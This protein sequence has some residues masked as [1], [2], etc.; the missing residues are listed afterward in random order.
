MKYGIKI[1]ALAMAPV[2]LGGAFALTAGTSSTASASTHHSHQQQMP[3]GFHYRSAWYQIDELRQAQR[4]PEEGH[5]LEGQR[6]YAVSTIPARMGP[7]IRP[8]GKRNWYRALDAGR[9]SG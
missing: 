5:H 7:S 1:A 4:R 2:I 3:A 6:R 9:G 8:S